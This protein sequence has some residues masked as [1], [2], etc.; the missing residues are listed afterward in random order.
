M[1]RLATAVFSSMFLA[2]TYSIS[3]LVAVAIAAAAAAVLTAAITFALRRAERAEIDRVMEII[4]ACAE[5]ERMPE[6]VQ[7][8]C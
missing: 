8:V 7:L 6:P 5:S 4:D 1:T 2:G 3:P